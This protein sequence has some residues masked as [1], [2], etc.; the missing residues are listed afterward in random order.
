[1]IRA[2]HITEGVEADIVT[3]NCGDRLGEDKRHHAGTKPR[4]SP[5]HP[6]PAPRRQP[7]IRKQQD[8][9]GEQG[10]CGHPQRLQDDSDR[11]EQEPVVAESVGEHR[12]VT[13]VDARHDQQAE[14]EQDP[15]DRV[16]RLVARDHDTNRGVDQYG[17]HRRPSIEDGQLMDEIGQRYGYGSQGDHQGAE[18]RRDRRQRKAETADSGFSRHQLL[19]A[20]LLRVPHAASRYARTV[21]GTL[22]SST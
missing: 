22:P 10:D 21:P 2:L 20:F 5:Q 15:A 6:P 7:A 4:I 8:D 18:D 16:A 3:S 13:G 12:V 17:G 9:Q 11:S 1:M 19:L 14:N